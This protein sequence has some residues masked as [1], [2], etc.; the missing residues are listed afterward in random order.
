MSGTARRRGRGATANDNLSE[1]SSRPTLGAP[2]A[3]P[4][5][6]DGPGSRGS[7][8]GPASTGRGRGSNV[9]STTG[10]AP[11]SAPGS[12]PTSP[13][14]SQTGF[15]TIPPSQTSSQPGSR[16]GVPPPSQAPILSDPARD[17]VHNRPEL[18]TDG[19]KNVD[20]PP[21]FYQ[22]NRQVREL[23]SRTVACFLCF[24]SSSLPLA[25]L[26]LTT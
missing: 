1:T 9:P 25:S 5:G 7:A 13:R 23:D 24:N 17:P 26:Q 20:L 16:A 4:G 14:L 2:S 11:G 18:R 3:P 15:G 10:S 12:Q 6:F 19:M 22:L 8:S 21:S